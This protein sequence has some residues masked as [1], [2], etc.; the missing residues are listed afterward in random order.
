MGSDL[1]LLVP[2]VRAHCYLCFGVYMFLN[3]PCI[4]L[5]DFV[6]LSLGS[7]VRRFLCAI[8]H[9]FRVILGVNVFG[10]VS[11]RLRVVGVASGILFLEIR[12]SLPQARY[13]RGA[14]CVIL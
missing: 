7:L 9:H 10:L 11:L 1:V 4:S 6:S 14:G 5:I 2:L 12:S 3:L 13:T 8:H